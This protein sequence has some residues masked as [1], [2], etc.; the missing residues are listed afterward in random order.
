MKTIRIATR[1]SELA[2]TQTRL[3]ADH[4]VACAKS[5]GEDVNYELVS[6]TTEGDRRLDKSLASFGG[7]GDAEGFGMVDGRE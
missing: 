2:M 6:M 3:V 5:L 7:K 4:L 1:K